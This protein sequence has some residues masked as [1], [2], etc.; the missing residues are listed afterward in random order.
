MQGTVAPAPGRLGGSAQVNS[1]STSHFV[2]RERELLTLRT[3]RAE[4]GPGHGNVVMLV[5]ETGIGNTEPARAFA[6]AARTRGTV[7][8]SGSC[9]RHSDK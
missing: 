8:L 9:Y 4:A 2:G 5:G 6:E 1:Q 7:V 3:Q